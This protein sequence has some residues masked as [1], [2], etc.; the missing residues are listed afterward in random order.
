M[1][2]SIPLDGPDWRVKGYLGIEG[3]LAAAQRGG[4][5]GP[6]WLPAEVP[7]SVVH[8]L[9]RAGEVPDPYVER[10]SLSI[11]W[12]PERAW[13]YRRRVSVP[14]STVAAGTR[15]WLRFDGVDFGGHVFLDGEP[16]GRHEGMFAPFEFEVGERLRPGA[17]HELAVVVEPA[18]EPS[19][20][21]A[22]RAGCGSTRAA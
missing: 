18:P 6:G 4:E 15:A 13:L 16:I 11:E 20:R 9:W 21:R 5:G 2:R 3:A 7:G 8:D 12:V 22:A 10:N 19:R 14:D 1:R 17:D